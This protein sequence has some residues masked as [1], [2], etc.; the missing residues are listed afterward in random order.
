MGKIEEDF[1]MQI[2]VIIL[3]GFL[4]AYQFSKFIT[5][6]CNFIHE[7]FIQKCHNTLYFVYYLA[8]ALF[9]INSPCSRES[10]IHCTSSNQY[11]VT[12]KHA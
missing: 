11:W 8:K 3:F 7:G 4:K 9:S 5:V 10:Q 2:A 12:S 1:Q 6:V